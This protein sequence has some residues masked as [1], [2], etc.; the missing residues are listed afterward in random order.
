MHAAPRATAI[1]LTAALAAGPIALH[2][3]ALSAQELVVA[4]FGGSFADNTKACA[5]APFEKASGA[6]V[7]FVLG[8]SVQN[9]AKLRATKGKPDFDIAYMDLQIVKQ[10]KAEGLLD[11]LDKSKLANLPDIYASAVD[12]DLRFVGFMYSGT[13]I[14]YNPKAVKTPPTS[15]G[16]L[17]DPVYRGKIAPADISGTSGIHFL[18]ATARFKGGSIENLDP[19]FAAIK[20]LKPHSVTLY[21]QA[22][23]IV[24]LIE[25]GDI[26]IAPWY[27]DRVGAAALKGVPVALA[28][29][30]EGAVGILPTVSIPQGAKSKALAERYVDTL[31]SPDSQKCFAEK[32]YAG[33]TNRKVELAPDLAKLVP[34]KDAVEKMYFPDTDYISKNLPSWNERWG[35]EI[36]R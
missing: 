30:K 14:A 21:T 35:R 34:Y 31:L 10:A 1:A 26:V 29:P 16:D 27:I 12:P 18:I 20:E 7:T 2:A 8:S 6:K 23:Q 3:P 25:R 4:I 5:V 24:S 17:W 13:A 9:A 11:T 19:G 33:P 15:W 28:F 22:D 32:Q 36:A